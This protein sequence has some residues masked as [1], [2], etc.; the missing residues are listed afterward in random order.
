MQRLQAYLHKVQYYETDAMGI[1]HHSNYLRFMEEG[2]ND[3]TDQSGTMYSL[4]EE[5][6][7][8]CLVTKADCKYHSPAHYGETL[9]IITT[10]ESYNGVK[11]IYSYRL[12]DADT[13]VLRVSG[14]TEHC[15]IDKT[16]KIAQLKKSCPK[17]Y[18]SLCDMVGVV[19]D[20]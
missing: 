17:H 9:K 12:E 10:L 8:F 1:V 4:V 11:L 18:Q 3:F 20:G 6:G 14:R 15:F 16:G 13:G 19:A 5:E 7:F 2:R